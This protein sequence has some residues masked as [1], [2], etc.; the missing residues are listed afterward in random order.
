MVLFFGLVFCVTPHPLGNCYADGLGSMRF[1]N[2]AK[3]VLGGNRL[4]S[5]CGGTYACIEI[6]SILLPKPFVDCWSKI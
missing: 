2:V 4:L 5:L 6:E 1:G 3:L